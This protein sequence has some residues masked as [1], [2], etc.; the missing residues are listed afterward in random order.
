MNSNAPSL[1]YDDARPRW[2]RALF[3]DGPNQRNYGGWNCTIMPDAAVS[4]EQ[5]NEAWGWRAWTGLK[6]SKGLRGFG[7]GLLLVWQHE[8][9]ELKAPRRA[10]GK[11]HRLVTAS[12]EQG[13]TITAP[14]YIT[15]AS[16]P[17]TESR[18]IILPTFR[19]HHLH[20]SLVVTNFAY[21]PYFTFPHRG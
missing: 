16:A 15:P 4:N 9:G 1:C 14:C 11:K 13:G 12:T 18:S 17:R 7:T 2:V 8:G 21:G 10:R 19:L 6:G 5:R 3:V 20:T